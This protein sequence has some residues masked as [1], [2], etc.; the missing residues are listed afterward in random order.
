MVLGVA[1]P[2]ALPGHVVDEVLR[3]VLREEVRPE[4]LITA[5]PRPGLLGG[6]PWKRRSGHRGEDLKPAPTLLHAAFESSS[7]AQ[8]QIFRILSDA[9]QMILR[10]EEQM[11]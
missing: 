10:G 1:A 9:I 8:I 7:K 3:S 4:L 11:I 2:V 6:G 5:D